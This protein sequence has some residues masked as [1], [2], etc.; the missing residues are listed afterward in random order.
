MEPGEI[1]C[2]MSKRTALEAGVWRTADDEHAVAS[3]LA[4][5]TKELGKRERRLVMGSGF[6]DTSEL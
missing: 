5:K 4:M 6:F 2:G 3:R 1:E